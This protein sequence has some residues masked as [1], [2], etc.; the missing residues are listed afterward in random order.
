MGLGGSPCHR[1]IPGRFSSPGPSLTHDPGGATITVADRRGV[2]PR[3][4]RAGLALVRESVTTKTLVHDGDRTLAGQVAAA[5]VVPSSAGGLALT[6]MA[7]VDLVRAMAWAVGSLMR[8]T[9]AAPPPFVI[10]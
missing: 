6:G 1:D 10:R 7:R 2:G 9:E 3:E 8:P 5:R 4:L